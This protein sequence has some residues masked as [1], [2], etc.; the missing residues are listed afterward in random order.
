MMK[1]RRRFWHTSCDTWRMAKKMNTLRLEQMNWGQA[2]ITNRRPMM[3]PAALYLMQIRSSR[4]KIAPLK[5]RL[6]VFMDAETCN[7]PHDVK[8]RQGV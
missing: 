6:P 5:K 2:E 1:T 4:L 8:I 7:L 3:E